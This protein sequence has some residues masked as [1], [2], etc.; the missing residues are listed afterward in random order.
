MNLEKIG[1]TIK[2][3]RLKNTSLSQED[4]A[5]LI[6]LERSY[7]SRVESGKKNITLETLDIICKGLGI[8]VTQFFLTYEEMLPIKKEE[9]N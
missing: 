9:T 7:M 4:F 8:T 6:G 2:F 5:K 3:L 1:E